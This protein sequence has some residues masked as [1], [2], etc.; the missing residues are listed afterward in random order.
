MGVICFASLKG[1]V[2]KT[3]L[4]VN[5]AHAFARRGC[6][7]LLIDTDPLAHATRFFEYSLGQPLVSAAQLAEHVFA[8]HDFRETGKPYKVIHEPDSL[9]VKVRDQL[10][11]LPGGE[12]YRH[13][14]FG[15]GARAFNHRYGD[16]L[17]EFSY[18]FDQIV[19]DTAP[20][21]NVITRAALAAANLVVVPVDSSAMSV[22]GLEALIGS[23]AHIKGPT[24]CIA[25]TMVDRRASRVQRLS[26]E[27]LSS[28]INLHHIEE[29]TNQVQEKDN[30]PIYLLDSVIFR[31]EQQN[32]LSFIGRT[33]FEYREGMELARAY[34]KMAGELERLLAVAEHSEDEDVSN[35]FPSYAA[36]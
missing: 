28:S 26:D 5:I 14:S 8:K 9:L 15:R 35:G 23:A 29:E 12:E 24:W 11:L 32:L 3:S 7:T 20:E 34:H 31:T 27:Q 30:S 18:N 4:S 10:T 19:I 21:F 13:F 16:L 1:G 17:R 36:G 25:R 33:S 6:E 2:G 22:H